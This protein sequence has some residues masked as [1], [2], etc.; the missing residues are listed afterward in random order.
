MN[1]PIKQF[2][3]ILQF[4]DISE[5]LDNYCRVEL[6]SSDN[7]WY[8]DKLKKYE[9]VNRQV[10]FISLPDVIILS[11]NRFDN[12]NNKS[13]KN[14]RFTLDMTIDF[15]KY[16]LDSNERQLYNL[17]GVCCHKGSSNYGHYTS[18]VKNNINDKWYLYD[19]D[20]IELLNANEYSKVLEL[21]QPYVFFFSKSIYEQK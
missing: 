5:C 4:S 13:R 20:N 19:D 21:D 1:D 15:G 10:K 7:A 6:L 14:V 16:M 17:Y 8:N 12:F 2:S 18:I 3:P 11:L 9:T